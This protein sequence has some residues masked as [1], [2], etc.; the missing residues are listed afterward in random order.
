[1]F[2]VINLWWTRSAAMMSAKSALRALVP[3]RLRSK[4]REHHVSMNVT[5]IYGPRTVQL[6]KNEAAVTCVLRHGEYY[7]DSFI[8]HY[9]KMGFRHI[10]FLENGSSDETLST[11]K[12]YDNVSV[13]R[14]TLPISANQRLF[15]KYLAEHSIR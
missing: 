15:K 12:Q 14:S 9:S 5:H 3:R 1:M 6:S 7:I 4:L 8:Q 13:C 2:I 11:V 10:F